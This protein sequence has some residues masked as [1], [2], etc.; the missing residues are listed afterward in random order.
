MKKETQEFEQGNN[1]VLNVLTGVL[2]GGMAG[3]L[4]MLLMAPQ[5]GKKTRMLIQEKGIELRDQTS[6]M[7]EDAFAQISKDSRKLSREGQRK[8]KQLIHQSQSLVEEKIEN[9][10][11]ALKAGK[12]A[13]MNT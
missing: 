2:V 8:A 5:S 4:A 6:D 11:D 7:L 12:K 13:L 3:A 10:A 9:V 1:N